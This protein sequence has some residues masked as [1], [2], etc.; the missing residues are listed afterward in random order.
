MAARHQPATAL[1]LFCLA[2]IVVVVIRLTEGG[3][4]RWLRLRPSKRKSLTCALVISQRSQGLE[5]LRGIQSYP[6]CS[7]ANPLH[8]IRFENE[9]NALSIPASDRADLSVVP[10]GYTAV[11]W[12]LG[13][14]RMTGCRYG[15]RFLHFLWVRLTRMFESIKPRTLTLRSYFPT[16]WSAETVSANAPSLDTAMPITM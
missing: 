16:I 15:A 6:T 4:C 11:P 9:K 7:L 3:R 1:R 10:N 8:I 2:H 12:M 13:A 5:S 14:V